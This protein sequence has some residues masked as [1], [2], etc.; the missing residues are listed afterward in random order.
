MNSYINII[1]LEISNIINLLYDNLITNNLLKNNLKNLENFLEKEINK[2]ILKINKDK[3][4]KILKKE[5]QINKIID[6]I[7]KYIFYYI[8][9]FT[10]YYIKDI[11]EYKNIIIKLKKNNNFLKYVDNNNNIL[12]IHDFLIKFIEI[13][14][15]LKNKNLTNFI[16]DKKYKQV[17]TFIN[18][19][20]DE[21]IIDKLVDNKIIN[22][23]NILFFILIKYYYLKNDIKNVYNILEEDDNLEIS[24]ID[25]VIPINNY[26]DQIT[27]ENI[28]DIPEKKKSI[29]NDL[30]DILKKTKRKKLDNDNKI[31]ILLNSKL[32]YPI[33]ED[34]LRYHKSV[35][36]YSNVQNKK[37]SKLKLIVESLDIIKNFNKL[38][39]NQLKKIEKFLYKK[40]Q[41]RNAI[42][43]NEFDEINIIR[44]LI[45]Q[46][47]ST[48][49]KNEYIF[50]L[51]EF[52][53][54][55]YQNYSS[56]KNFGF[57]YIPKKTLLT[58][59]YSNIEY[60]KENQENYIETRNI[61]NDNNANIIG[62]LFSKD[63]INNKV[64]NINNTSKSI[65]EFIEDFDFKKPNNN[66]WLFDKNLLLNNNKINYYNEDNQCNKC[67]INVINLYH[68]YED[69]IY[70]LI[71]K[72]ITNL[73]YPSLYLINRLV[74]NIQLQ[75]FNIE[76]LLKENKLNKQI[77]YKI[78]KKSTNLEENNE[79]IAKGI[80]GNV[81]KIPKVKTEKIK[82]N[83]LIFKSNLKE[84]KNIIRELISN[85]FICKHH[86]DYIDINNLDKG[87]QL[88]SK[89]FFEFTK[90]YTFINHE[91]LFI[92]KS[93][94]ELLPIKRYAVNV[95]KE[96]GDQG[97][98][99]YINS[100][101]RLKDHNEYK[102]YTTVIDF[103]DKLV[104]KIAL[105]SNLTLYIGNTPENKFNRMRIVKKTIDLII[106]NYT[107]YSKTSKEEKI[108][109]IGD[110]SKYYNINP[111]TSDFF[112][113]KL[114]DNIFKF[115]DDE[116]DKYKKKKINNIIY[117]I[118]F[119]ILLDTN[120]YHI[121]NFN[122]DKLCNYEIFN[123][124]YITLFKSIKI[125][126]NRSTDI[127]DI[128]Y[129]PILCY[130]IFYFSCMILKFKLWQGS[131]NKKF[132]FITLKI[133]ILS[134]INLFNVI[135][136]NNILYKNNYILNQATSIYYFKLKNLLKDKK[137]FEE[138]EEKQ[139]K[140]IFFNKN[141]N[142]ITISKV[143][144]PT[145]S[146]DGK[147]V[148]YKSLNDNIYYNK[149]PIH[150]LL[151][152]DESYFIQ[153]DSN[154]S[155]KINDIFIKNYHN[156]IVK[157]YDEKVNKRSIVLTELELKKINNNTYTTI[158]K[159]Y[160][161]YL[162]VKLKNNYNTNI[163]NNN[164]YNKY[165]ES[166]N[167]LINYENV[168]NTDK[169]INNLK[170]IFSQYIQFDD[171]KVY[172]DDN[173]YVISNDINGN[174]LD[175]SIYIMQNNVKV[176]NNHTFFKSDVYEI[177]YNKYIMYYDIFTNRYLGLKNQ[178]N[179]VNINKGK[180]LK[181]NYSV[182]MLFSLLGFK[183]QYINIDNI[184]NIDE[185]LYDIFKNRDNTLNN[186][187][188][189]FINYIFKIKYNN[190][191]VNNKLLKKYL[192]NIKLIILNKNK[193]FI[194]NNYNNIV[195]N[196]NYNKKFK[197]KIINNKYI[198]ILDIINTN[199]INNVNNYYFNELN[200]LFNFNKKI[201]NI[202]IF[203]MLLDIIIKEFKI[204]FSANKNDL[205]ILLYNQIL[206]FENISYYDDL[207]NTQGIYN[208]I[209]E[210]LTEDEQTILNDNNYSVQQS[211]EALDFDET[212]EE[213]DE[214]DQLFENLD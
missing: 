50:N 43:M 39:D 160:M 126:T 124:Y 210:E 48:F 40:L 85:K 86:L 200:Y 3:I 175:K 47:K 206:T 97:I 203:K 173:I 129:Y 207:E 128:T 186:I 42:L 158:V 98:N 133:I 151:L 177:V 88:Y 192:N 2:Y 141:K 121:I 172:I 65:N 209:K 140:R 38:N 112:I 84:K 59:R 178:N 157:N 21:K 13:I 96:D 204:N 90:K 201:N 142:V 36:L 55:F 73:K 7:K 127:I 188:D 114:E 130:Y 46:G 107:I 137:L 25:I 214:N 60:L 123:K 190:T 199:N 87:G 104:D 150:K 34:F 116:E 149:S 68:I 62:L 58:I 185:Y 6:I 54:S 99:I 136:E 44:K 35:D 70:N 61:S 16:N 147:L 75:Y 189:R 161:N 95:F 113:F 5:N 205:N 208:E 45:L 79:Y 24:Y 94:K 168:N 10:N 37:I 89:K 202:Y 193:K 80:E 105:I 64:K 179:Y 196:I 53:K 166:I 197:Y 76:L 81:I 163:E 194:F 15:N 57:N 9:L 66:Y 213:G 182:K 69:Q 115:K 83:R 174:Q 134:I 139:K 11:N 180:Y 119:S 20:L 198:D 28:L 93:C 111:K 187:F 63:P 103:I 176:I 92:C 138:I 56:I 170:S 117:N 132:D 120:K 71:K 101:I 131:E 212:I 74:N 27:I 154:D 152:N 122:I 23:H 164:K 181:I 82:D 1:E 30:F 169:L 4:K 184:D 17:L 29:I 19:E 195:N 108:K 156:N 109:R 145:I 52:R 125:K 144:F 26:I 32:V 135:C 18:N 106:N 191:I 67:K 91:D 102:E 118:I 14:K 33:V 12:H 22:Y 41:N 165:V 77:Y 162:N 143:N 159:N 51:L 110:L 146:I 78:L 148:L 183:S 100:N 155:K 49:Q 31:D 72:T 167:K 211:Q 8:S 153:L 171:N